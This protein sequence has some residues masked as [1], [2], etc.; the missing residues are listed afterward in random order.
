MIVELFGD[1]HLPD[2][3]A[4][5]V[6][7]L[8]AVHDP[9]PVSITGISTILPPSPSVSRP[10]RHKQ[11]GDLL[12]WSAL[13]D[14]DRLRQAQALRVKALKCRRWADTACDDETAARLK[15]MASDYERQAEAFEQDI[16]A[17]QFQQGR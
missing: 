11:P 8:R 7:A 4:A 14:H 12:C 6:P 2:A 5:L 17:P 15:A 16:A 1:L 10:D 13:M 9:N 3:T